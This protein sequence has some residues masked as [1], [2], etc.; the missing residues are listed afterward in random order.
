MIEFACID[1]LTGCRY[2]S[3]DGK[4][5]K[6]IERKYGLTDICERKKIDRCA[7]RE[8]G[9]GRKRTREME[10]EELV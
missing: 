9:Y 2:N 5:E 10:V 7:S 6:E 1:I 3:K 8:F 4:R